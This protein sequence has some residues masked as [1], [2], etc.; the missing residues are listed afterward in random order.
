VHKVDRSV[1]GL[2]AQQQCVGPLQLPLANLG[3]TAHT[4]FGITGTAVAC[5]EQPIKG[6]V[7]SAAMARMT[8]AEAMTNIMWAKISS[9]EDIKASGNW[10]YAAKLPGE[11][12][13][14]YDACE[15]L[16]DSLLALGAGIDGGKDSLSM[17]A[18]CGNELVKA[19]GELTLTC[20]VT[21]PDVTK[22]VTPDL[23]CPTK[24]GGTTS[25]LFVD[26]GGGKARMGGTALAQVYGQ[27]GDESPDVED[28][29]VLKNAFLVVQEL[30]DNRMV[31][32]G[33]RTR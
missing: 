13:K 6:L 17:A 28:F 25:L 32:A 27:I 9:I 4:H 21:C 11:G 20:Y 15:A 30:I 7:N 29:G 22:T 8:V 12:A 18:Q 5:G 23:K 24:C 33:C 14:M 2:I 26:L 31:L 10:M 3:I 19:P 1:T 16:R